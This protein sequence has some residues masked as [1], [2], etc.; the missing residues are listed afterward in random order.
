MRTIVINNGTTSDKYGLHMDNTS[1]DK[2]NIQRASNAQLMEKLVNFGPISALT[3][4]ILTMI[5][6]AGSDFGH[7]ADF[8]RPDANRRIEVWTGHG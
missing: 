3:T 1:E 8:R 5:R 2:V 4:G 6:I 7:G